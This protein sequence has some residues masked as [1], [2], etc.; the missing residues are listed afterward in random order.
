[1][2]NKKAKVKYTTDLQPVDGIKDEV[3]NN[4]IN[5]W[6]SD[7]KVRYPIRVR[8]LKQ[9]KGVL[10][11]PNR[12]IFKFEYQVME[13]TE[14]KK[15]TVTWPIWYHSSQGREIGKWYKESFTKDDP[16]PDNQTIYRAYTYIAM[17]KVDHINLY[18]TYGEGHDKINRQGHYPK[19]SDSEFKKLLK[20]E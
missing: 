8:N 6:Q 14:D 18:T 3:V 5:K 9:D 15:A 20:G 2:S 4:I 1:M 19:P 16:N 10:F 17:G 12:S 7:L 11:D 13:D